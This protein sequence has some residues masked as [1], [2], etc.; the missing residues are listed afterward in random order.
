MS[1]PTI[2]WTGLVNGREVLFCG[3][4][5]RQIGNV[6]P[7]VSSRSMQLTSSR[8]ISS[9]RHPANSHTPTKARIISIG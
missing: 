1:W 3:T 7:V 2:A 4:R 9:I 8:R 6:S 5:S